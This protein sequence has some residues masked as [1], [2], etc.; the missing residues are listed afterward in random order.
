[1]TA[2][3]Q[4]IVDAVIERAEQACRYVLKHNEDAWSGDERTAFHHGFL[5]LLTTSLASFTR[6]LASSEAC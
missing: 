5:R 2:E 3:Q 6:S 1:M 4:A